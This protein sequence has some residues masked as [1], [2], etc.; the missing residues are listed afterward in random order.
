VLCPSNSPLQKFQIELSPRFLP[1]LVE[2]RHSKIGLHPRSSRMQWEMES[3][4]MECLY[5]SQ[6]RMK[7]LVLL[8]VKLVAGVRF[9]EVCYSKRRVTSSSF[10]LSSSQIDVSFR[11][12][13]F[14]SHYWRSNAEYA[15]D[16]TQLSILAHSRFAQRKT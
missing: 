11:I 14:C 12:S 4:I 6:K 16:F 1:C 3:Q 7:P 10:L 8:L 15:Y 13:D 2:V 5:T 9:L